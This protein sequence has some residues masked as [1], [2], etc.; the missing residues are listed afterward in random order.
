VNALP[1][2]ASA[3]L[4]LIVVGILAGKAPLAEQPSSK[5]R[6][7]ATTQRN[8][9]LELQERLD[10]GSAQLAFEEHGYLRSL[11]RELDVPESSQMLVYS[12]TSLQRDWISP[13][14]PRAIYFNDDIMVGYC[15]EGR[16]LELAA[17]D[18]GTGTAFFTLEQTRAE[19]P[20][21][22]RQ[23]LTCVGCHATSATQ[24]VTG[25]LVRSLS[26]DDEGR[27][28]L[29]QATHRID[30][31]SP[32][33]ER[34]GGWYVT[35]SSGRQQHLGNRIGP[36]PGESSEQGTEARVLE[37]AEHVPAGRY[38]TPHSDIVALMV[39][40]HQSG[41]LNRLAKAGSGGRRG[42]R[43]ST[44]DAPNAQLQ[45]AGDAVVKHLLFT[46]EA[47]LTDRIEGTSSFAQDFAARGPRD[48]KGRSLRDFDLQ[49][50][51]FRYPCS[52]L[53]YSR[54]FDALPGEVKDYVYRRLWDTLTGPQAEQEAPHLSAEDRQAIVEILR[55]T[56]DGLPEYW[57][58]P[59]SG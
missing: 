7:R 17:A 54:S 40:E 1:W 52:Y 5:A 48:S 26:V 6:P 35:G 45:A 30:H 42:R 38:L 50:R 39:F 37:L 49:T 29:D 4:A 14:T 32:L 9:A 8:V 53:I 11:L 58:S 16:I 3:P 18:G 43:D 31:S 10:A 46:D 51:L 22:E 15:H 28:L 47:P 59:A 23:G 20:V 36:P 27:L 2:S 33:A 21:L 12:K 44:A 13:K 25:L 57:R 56:K 34:W 19:K 41:M 24:G 55:E